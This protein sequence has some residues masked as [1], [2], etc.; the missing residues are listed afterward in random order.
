MI[1]KEEELRIIS[2]VL[3]G[4]DA[5]EGFDM[6]SVTECMFGVAKTVLTDEEYVQLIT[7][8]D[9]KPEGFFPTKLFQPPKFCKLG[10]LYTKADARKAWEGYI[11]TGEVNWRKL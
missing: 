7:R 9:K 11:E 10:H 1:S 3:T 8:R 2:K 6:S 4:L 5:Y